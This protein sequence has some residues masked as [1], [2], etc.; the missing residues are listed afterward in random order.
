ML[1]FLFMM[2]A[3][4]AQ[5]ASNGNLAVSAYITSWGYCWVHGTADIAFG[6]LDPLNPRNVQAT[7]NVDVR[8]LGFSGNFTVGVTRA[9]SSPLYL[10]NG[11]NT[12]PYT[13]ELPTSA[14]G[15]AFI[16]GAISIPVTAHIQA[17]DYQFA[18]AGSYSDIVKVQIN[19]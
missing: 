16:I 2:M 6:D 1:G 18:P 10:E 5:A 17:G 7:G 11:S 3:V 13:L 4:P 14:T 12:I 9:T 8:C 15:T 19:P